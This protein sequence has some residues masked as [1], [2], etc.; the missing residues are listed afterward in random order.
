MSAKII[1]LGGLDQGD[2]EWSQFVEDLKEGAVRAVFIVEKE[3][4]SV[5]VGTNSTDRRSVVYDF[6]RL[7]Q[8]CLNIINESPEEYDE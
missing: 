4:G 5:M 6:Y 1:Q 3:D 7:Q 8:F 2:E